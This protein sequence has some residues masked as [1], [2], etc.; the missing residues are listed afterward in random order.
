[1]PWTFA[2]PAA[3]LPLRKLGLKHL[4]IGG[5]VVG[6]VSP[7]IGYYVG[8]FDVAAIAHTTVGLLI[9]CLPTGLI[10][11]ALVRVLH[12]PVANMLPEPHRSALLSMRQVPR[13]VSPP[14]VFS[15]VVSII[16]GAM[17][18]NVWDSFTHPAGY[19]VSKLPLLRESVGVIGTR[20]VPVYELLQHASTLVGLV[21]IVAAYVT[22]LRRVNASHSPPSPS[23]DRWRYVLLFALLA[24]AAILGVLLAYRIYRETTGAILFVRILICTTSVFAVAFCSVSLLLSYRQ[25]EN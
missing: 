18:H 10:L 8:R 4:S 14:V 5:L 21:V 15:V 17:T 22:W 19:M 25:R 23:N 24:G 12:R 2:H 11:F 6:S 3:V 7:D 9:L 1:M 13:L 16:I 20:R